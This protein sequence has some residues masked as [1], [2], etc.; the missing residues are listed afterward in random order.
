M[1]CLL[2]ECNKVRI[3]ITLLQLWGRGQQKLPSD[4]LTLIPSTWREQYWERSGYIL[5]LLSDITLMAIGNFGLSNMSDIRSWCFNFSDRYEG[6]FHFSCFF[7][8]KVNCQLSIIVFFLS[9][10]PNTY[11]FFSFFSD[12]FLPLVGNAEEKHYLKTNLLFKIN[13]EDNLKH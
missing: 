3:G 12:Y 8:A 1:L 9:R 6:N 13:C 4:Q 11:Y 7:N 5:L 2:T 10:D